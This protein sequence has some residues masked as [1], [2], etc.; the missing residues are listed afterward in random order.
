MAFAHQGIL[1]RPP[2]GL[3]EAPSPPAIA[4]SQ[5]LTAPVASGR[6]VTL[7]SR[8]A[9]VIGGI[10]S[11]M[12]EVDAREVGDYRTVSGAFAAGPTIPTVRSINGHIGI[13]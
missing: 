3:G 8:S 10:G 6:S 12:R 13:Q 7:S 1:V 9:A 4:S 5:P 11:L 2:F